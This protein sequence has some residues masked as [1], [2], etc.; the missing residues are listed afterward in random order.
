MYSYDTSNKG[1][2]AILSKIANNYTS[3]GKYIG[4]VISQNGEVRD[5]GQLTALPFGNRVRFTLTNPNGSN[6]GFTADCSFVLEVRLA[7]NK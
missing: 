1:Q 4:G 5:Y 6:A 3:A 2:S 7:S